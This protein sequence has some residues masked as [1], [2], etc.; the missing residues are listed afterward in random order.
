MPRS[1]L[2]RTLT[3]PSQ[4]TSPRAEAT[5]EHLVAPKPQKVRER[6]GVGGG[7]GDGR[8]IKPRLAAADNKEEEEKTKGKVCG[9][10]T[11]PVPHHAPNAGAHMEQ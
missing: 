1:P 7:I 6:G 3:P 11:A 4:A 2:T 9:T 5:Y 8:K 10:C